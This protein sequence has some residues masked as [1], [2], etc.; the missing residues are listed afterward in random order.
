MT[1]IINKANRLGVHK[2]KE[3]MTNLKKKNNPGTYWTDDEVKILKN[4]YTFTSNSELSDL[5]NKTRKSIGKKL[6]QLNLYR[7]KKE[8]DFM[9]AK[10][11]KKNSRDLNFE[12]VKEIAKTYNTRHEF[13]LKDYSAYNTAIKNNWINSICQHMI[14]GNISIPQLI[15]K[16][17]LEHFLMCKCS[18]NDRKVIRPLE[19][20]CYFKEY[21]FGWEY[22]GKYY[23]NDVDDNIKQIKCQDIGIK[24]FI[25]HEKNDNYRDY[26]ENIKNQLAEQLMEINSITNL[27]INKND[28]FKYKPNL[29]FPNVLTYDEK[30]IINGEKLT[31]VKKLNNDLYKKIIKYKLYEDSEYNIIYDIKK[32][33]KFENFDLY[34]QYL[35]NKKYKSFTELCKYEHP[36]RIVKM[37]K[38]E[39]SS[40]HNLFEK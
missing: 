15:L 20:D 17:I 31:N 30:K 19:I 29:I 32:N 13:Y 1:Y 4:N 24:L 26:E 12:T 37:F 8:K 9:T 22:N 25:I 10:K 23:H 33:N 39:I 7:T 3:F 38:Q 40:V 6:K 14:T 18:Y 34:I 36:H 27:N 16:D 11:V 21:N 28:L 35:K 2:S 5:L